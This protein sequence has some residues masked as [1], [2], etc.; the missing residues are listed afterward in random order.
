MKKFFFWPGSGSEFDQCGSTSLTVYIPKITN[1]KKTELVYFSKNLLNHEK[2]LFLNLIG[3]KQRTWPD[4]SHNT[5]I[6]S[7][8]VGCGYFER[9]GAARIPD[10]NLS[11]S[12]V[13]PDP[14]HCFQNRN[15]LSNINFDF[16]FSYLLLE[17]MIVSAQNQ[18]QWLK[19]IF[20]WVESSSAGTF[21]YKSHTG[22]LHPLELVPR[23]PHKKKNIL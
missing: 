10:P 4:C 13:D 12:V 14:Q 18:P 16:W 22:C 5:P 19:N 20:Y 17:F 11:N 6:S 9:L 21:T 15:A 2:R 3:I 23:M 8:S 1:P 7:V